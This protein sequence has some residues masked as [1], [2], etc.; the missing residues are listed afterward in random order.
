MSTKVMTSFA[1]S[2]VLMRIILEKGIQPEEFSRQIGVD[3]HQVEDPDGRIPMES[4]LNLWKLAI[5]LTGDPALALHL[6][7]KTGLQ[8]IHFVVSLARH[9]SNL[10]EA[11]YHISKY[12]KLISEAEQ[13][14]IFDMG[15]SIKI[16]LTNIYPEYKN[17]WIPEHHTSLMVDVTRSLV[18]EKLN[19]LEIHFQ[20]DAPEYAHMYH[21]IFKAPVTFGQ[22]EDMVV[23][24]KSDFIRPIASHD[25]NV[26]AALKNYAELSLKKI[27]R[28][29]SLQEKIYSH[30]MKCLPDGGVDIKTISKRMNMDPSTLYRRLKAEDAT[31]KD[32]LVKIK[33]ELAKN[34]LLQGMSSSQVTYLIG[35]SDPAAFQRAFKRWFGISPGKYRNSL[36]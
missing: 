21:E 5:H 36:K 22:P 10:L 2:R 20:H 8:H 24:R 12:A 3:P 16:I 4:A 27:T 25:P 17:K 33:Q 6:R 26:E 13:Y 35:F 31:F 23:F 7:E 9:S 34:Y 11:V 1:A 15:D 29:G 18:D 30:I 28:M 14:D 19:P 32:L